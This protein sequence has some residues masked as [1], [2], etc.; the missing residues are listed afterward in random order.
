MPV[1]IRQVKACTLLVLRCWWREG[2]VRE[3]AVSVSEFSVLSLQFYSEPKNI[4]LKKSIFLFKKLADLIKINEKKKPN[5][6]MKD[7][8]FK[9]SD[10]TVCV[11]NHGPPPPAPEDNA[12]M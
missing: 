2:C 8:S 11:V 12:N 6:Q 10:S 5:K 7:F 9:Y 4:A 1:C 3:E